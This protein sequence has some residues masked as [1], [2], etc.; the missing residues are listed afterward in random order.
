M[1]GLPRLLSQLNISVKLKEMIAKKLL[2]N[3]GQYGG[4]PILQVL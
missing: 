4:K 1:Y 3:N 2:N